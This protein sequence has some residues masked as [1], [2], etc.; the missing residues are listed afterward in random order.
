MLRMRREVHGASVSKQSPTSRALQQ[1]RKDGWL[2]AVVEK[3]NPGARVRQDLFGFIDIVAIPGVYQTTLGICGIQVTT[4]AHMAERFTKIASPPVLDK[5]RAWLQAGN[6]V[7]IWGY[8]KR[9]PRGQRKV[10]TLTRRAVT[11][12]DLEGGGA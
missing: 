3:W 8:A 7:E 1:L 6:Q 12:R 5:A 4:A 10:W 11:L 2:P 9:G